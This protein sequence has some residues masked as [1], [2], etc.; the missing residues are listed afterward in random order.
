MVVVI[1]MITIMMI[2]II[3]NIIIIMIIIIS[4]IIVV[5]VII[6][7]V[8][9]AVSPRFRCGSAARRRRPYEAVFGPGA[10]T[11]HITWK[12]LAFSGPCGISVS[13]NIKPLWS[14]KTLQNVVNPMVF[15]HVKKNIACQK[16]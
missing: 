11:L 14:T 3:M 1:I 15:D 10:K 7:A 4:I 12:N 2:I 13:K 8:V 6:G 9:R 16:T 5:V